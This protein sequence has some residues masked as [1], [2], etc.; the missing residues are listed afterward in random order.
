MEHILPQYFWLGKP[1]IEEETIKDV[2]KLSEYYSKL[3]ELMMPSLSTLTSYGPFYYLFAY[4]A[5]PWAKNLA[6]FFNT[7]EIKSIL[8][9]KKQPD[10]KKCIRI[11]TNAALKEMILPGLIAVVTPLAVGFLMGAEALGGLLAGNITTG[12]LLAVTLSSAGGA[13]D[14]AK[15]YV[16]KGNF[17]GE[18]SKVHAATVIGDTVGDP[19]KDTSG[20]SLNI[21]IKLVAIVSIVFLPLFI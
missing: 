1:Q 19:C 4:W 5:D 15:K 18:G 6:C 21:L 7:P 9:G 16:E 3:S 10:Y 17:G 8:K 14:N 13:W 12:F 2:L 20:P 11:S